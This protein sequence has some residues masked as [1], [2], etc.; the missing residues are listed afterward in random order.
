MQTGN[1]SIGNAYKLRI[2]IDIGGTK[3]NLGCLSEDGRVVENRVV[4][5]PERRDAKSIARLVKG[6]LEA[7]TRGR[8]VSSCGIGIPGT[9]SEDGKTVVSAPNLGWENEAFAALFERETGISASLV[10]DSRA[11]ALAEYLFGAGRGGKVVVCVTLGTGIGTGI[12]IDGKIYNGA[13]GASGETGHMPVAA[14]GRPC[15]CGRRGCL[16]CYAAG[17]GLGVTAR[18]LYGDGSTAETLFSKAEGGDAHA[19][20]AVN[21]AVELLV[22]ALVGT[23]N[24]LSPDRL[25]FSGGMS[26][27]RELFCGPIIKGINERR[28]AGGTGREL[29][30][31][32]AELGAD[33][34]LIGAA[35]A[36]SPPKA[37][38]KNYAPGDVRLSAS[39]MC[40]DMLRLGEQLAELE[41][42]GTDWIHCDIMDGHFVPNLMLGCELVNRT[43]EVTGLPYD[44]HLMTE[45][46]EHIIPLFDLRPGDVVSVHWES[47]PHVQRAIQM[48]KATGASAAVALNPST[49]VECVRDLLADVDMVLVMTVN[50]GYAGQKLIPQC[51]DKIKRLRRYLDEAGYPR[52]LIEVDGNC[53]FENVPLM[54]KAGARVFVVGSSSVFSPSTTIAEGSA[55]LRSLS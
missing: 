15:G 42:A 26:A 5:V 44:I 23:I 22:R 6:E 55:R 20:E 29:K 14:D 9:V 17:K 43:R 39:L 37:E 51:I 10:Q 2:G 13:L 38:P 28:Y 11:A 41:S 36:V 32:Y 45:S 47:T 31:G 12:V 3:I 4:R 19:L 50:P 18:E 35:F 1:N 30:I 33:A 46:P 25:L 8:A 40:A 27:H 34:P 7:L 16:E 24:L 53:S 52:V 21:E 48:I 54:Y 49:P